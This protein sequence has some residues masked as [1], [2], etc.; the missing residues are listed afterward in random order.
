MP[1]I[2]REEIFSKGQRVLKEYRFDHEGGRLSLWRRA[3]GGDMVKQWEVPLNGPVYDPL[4][5]LYNARLGTFGALT[6]RRH[7]EG[8]GPGHSQAPGDG[9]RSR[10]RHR[11][12]AGA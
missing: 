9:L 6:Q 8:N 3:G 1:L 4:T 7:P 2:Y 12:R 5:L 11:T 10:P